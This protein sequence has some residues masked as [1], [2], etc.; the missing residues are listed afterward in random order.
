[1]KP[2]R[3][4][5][6]ERSRSVRQEQ[7]STGARSNP[8]SVTIVEDLIVGRERVHAADKLG[9]ARAVVDV[10]R[11][12]PIERGKIGAAGDNAA[13]GRSREREWHSRERIVVHAVGVHASRYRHPAVSREGR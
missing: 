4:G 7:E 11:P 5:V 12:V 2:E 6:R 9:K 1:M 13:V 10:C 3:S 8:L